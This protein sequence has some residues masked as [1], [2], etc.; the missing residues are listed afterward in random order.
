M[1]N[2]GIFFTI[3]SILLL[4][5]IFYGRLVYFVVIWYIFRRLGI[6][7]QEKSGNPGWKYISWF[8]VWGKLIIYVKYV[9][10]TKK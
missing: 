7:H 2:F 9:N 3:W 1:E 5:E 4:L 8:E 10:L 6:L